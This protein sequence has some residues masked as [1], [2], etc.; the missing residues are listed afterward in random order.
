MMKHGSP[1]SRVEASHH[2]ATPAASRIVERARRSNVLSARGS[3]AT[4]A[5]HR[6]ATK[7]PSGRAS[8]SSAAAHMLGRIR[9]AWWSRSATTSTSANSGSVMVSEQ[10]SRKEG[11]RNRSG[12]A[13]SARSKP[14]ARASF[15]LFQAAASAIATVTSFAKG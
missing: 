1:V 10:I 14:C 3:R 13:N 12:T 15:T 4:D 8:G 2:A 11:C 7:N 6:S 5:A 9:P